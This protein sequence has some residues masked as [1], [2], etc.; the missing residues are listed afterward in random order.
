MYRWEEKTEG[1]HRTGTEEGTGLRGGG[2]IRAAE[3]MS[4][5]SG[6]GCVCVCWGG[7][8]GVDHLF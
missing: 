4:A 6:I 1:G 2:R 7:R 8:R 3:A 5:W